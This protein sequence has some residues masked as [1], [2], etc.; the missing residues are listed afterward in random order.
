MVDAP[1]RSPQDFLRRALARLEESEQEK[2]DP[3]IVSD[4]VE[5]SAEPIQADALYNAVLRLAGMPLH[6]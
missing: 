1:I 6:G 5:A 3:S 4:L 2:F